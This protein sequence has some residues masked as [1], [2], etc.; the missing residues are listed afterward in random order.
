[1]VIL[2]I[3]YIVTDVEA[4]W[5]CIKAVFNSKEKAEQYLIIDMGQDEEK[6]LKNDVDQFYIHE[7][8]VL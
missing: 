3:V 7:E 2:M 6:V 5:D 8:Q 1:M 4:G